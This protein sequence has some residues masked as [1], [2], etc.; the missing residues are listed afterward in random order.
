MRSPWSIVAGSNGIDCRTAREARADLLD[1]AA[2]AVLGK[3]LGIPEARL[4][5]LLDPV[6]FVHVTKS[7]GGVAPEEV[8]RMIADRRKNLE[9]ARARQL[10]RIETLEK[11]QKR[12]VS[13]LEAVCD[14]SNEQP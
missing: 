14:T 12:L 6:Y 8:A 3:K 2:E 7:Q 1:A 13:D 5:E 11:A 9:E 10:K 4:R